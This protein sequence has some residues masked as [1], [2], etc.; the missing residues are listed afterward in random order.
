MAA[1]AAAATEEVAVSAA[2]ADWGAKYVCQYPHDMKLPLGYSRDGRIQLYMSPLKTCGCKC[3][4]VMLIPYFR[5]WR[6]I[7]VCPGCKKD[8]PISDACVYSLV[9]IAAMWRKVLLKKVDIEVPT[10]MWQLLGMLHSTCGIADDGD[11]HELLDHPIMLD[12][13]AFV[14]WSLYNASAHISNKSLWRS[15]ARYAVFTSMIVANCSSC[16][17]L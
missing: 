14:V 5:K 7:P 4:L 9:D 2:A 12:H 17:P 10:S 1:A 16:I 13:N 15:T 6:Y 3:P 11:I 8:L